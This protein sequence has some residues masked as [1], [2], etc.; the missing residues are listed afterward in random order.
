LQSPP[1]RETADA[2]AAMAQKGLLAVEMEA[3]ALYAF[4]TAAPSRCCASLTSPTRWPG[5]RGTLNRARG[6]NVQKMPGAKARRS[7]AGASRP[8]TFQRGTAESARSPPGRNRNRGPSARATMRPPLASCNA[9]GRM[10]AMRRPLLPAWRFGQSPEKSAI[11]SGIF[12]SRPC[13]AISL[14]CR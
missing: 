10:S 12:A 1:F 8:A 4:A 9:T 5:T 2:I 6:A 3:A 14:S 11:E 7:L 13:S